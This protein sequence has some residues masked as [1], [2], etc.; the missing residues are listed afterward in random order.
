MKILTGFTNTVELISFNWARDA[1]VQ[2]EG[3]V[4]GGLCD[5]DVCAQFAF[6]EVECIDHDWIVFANLLRSDAVVLVSDGVL[7]ASFFSFVLLAKKHNKRVVLIDVN[8]ELVQWP[9]VSGSVYVTGYMTRVDEGRIIHVLDA[10]FGHSVVAESSVENH[11]ASRLVSLGGGLAEIIR[12]AADGRDGFTYYRYMVDQSR[13]YLTEDD[14]VE[15]VESFSWRI[16]RQNQLADVEVFNGVDFRPVRRD[17]C[18]RR[19]TF[20]EA[21]DLVMEESD[22][23][24]G[25]YSF[26]DTAFGDDGCRLVPGQSSEGNGYV[27][28][29]RKKDTPWRSDGAARW[30]ICRL[31]RSVTP[32]AFQIYSLPSGSGYLYHSWSPCQG[33][34][35]DMW[36]P[37]DYTRPLMEQIHPREISKV[38]VEHSEMVPRTLQFSL[39]PTCES[40]YW[41]IPADQTGNSCTRC[42]DFTSFRYYV[43]PVSQE[44]GER[45]VVRLWMQ[46]NDLMTYFLQVKTSGWNN[47][48]NWA[49]EE[50]CMALVG[51]D[52]L[53]E[54]CSRVRPQEAY[55]VVVRRT[56]Y[57]DDV[58]LDGTKFSYDP[59]AYYFDP[60]PGLVLRVT[61]NGNVFALDQCSG[62]YKPSNQ[63]IASSALRLSC[64]EVEVLE[65]LARLRRIPDLDLASEQRDEFRSY[66]AFRLWR[67]LWDE[68]GTLEWA[69]LSLDDSELFRFKSVEVPGSDI[70]LLMVK[71][72]ANESWLFGDVETYMRACRDEDGENSGFGSRSMKYATWFRT[73]ALAQCCVHELS[74]EQA[75]ELLRKIKM[76]VHRWNCEVQEYRALCDWETTW[77][78]DDVSVTGVDSLEEAEE[79]YWNTH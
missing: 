69:L 9:E 40:S 2:I 13:R 75:K 67:I 64:A 59:S 35:D 78:V 12:K 26:G 29:L 54:T 36:F 8:E 33:F 41:T 48:M 15:S 3:V 22:C 77:S 34:P 68:A 16:I 19:L 65:V 45:H 46:E 27:Y 31:Q 55:P 17:D 47:G 76:A 52:C 70:D 58:W 7:E 10:L 39:G 28:Y 5:R 60:D 62:G 24:G 30:K 21:V 51:Y 44:D 14:H 73:E 43:E 32:P 23:Y 63:A 53:P 11:C 18:S 1:G 37:D 71:C 38:L 50:I 61:P 56:G 57:D 25:P 66:D 74:L 72:I 79:L 49:R 4:P 20:A 42:F 6:E